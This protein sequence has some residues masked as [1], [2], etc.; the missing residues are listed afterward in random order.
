MRPDTDEAAGDILA[1]FVSRSSAP[2][3]T[4]APPHFRSALEQVSPMDARL[5]S[6]GSG[7]LLRLF[8]VFKTGN[9][10]VTLL[11]SWCTNFCCRS[12]MTPT[13]VE[14]EAWSKSL[15]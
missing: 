8:I 2:V 11:V 5:L 14:C 4:N 1:A 12:H 7:A 9:K 15:S 10:I 6:N 13:Q 3:A